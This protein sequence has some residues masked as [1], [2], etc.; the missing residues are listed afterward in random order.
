M[1]AVLCTYLLNIK[2]SKHSTYDRNKALVW[3]SKDF[4]FRKPSSSNVKGIYAK[5]YKTPLS[6]LT[7]LLK[8]V[9][10]YNK[11]IRK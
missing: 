4:K 1:I 5:C 11:R 3:L 9:A 10:D 6:Y 8:F 7:E 2:L